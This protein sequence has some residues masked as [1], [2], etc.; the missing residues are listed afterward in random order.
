MTC[1]PARLE[2]IASIRSDKVA[3]LISLPILLCC[4]VFLL[5][6]V[7]L[8]CFTVGAGVVGWRG[9]LGVL[10][11]WQ[12]SSVAIGTGQR[13]ATVSISRCAPSGQ[14]LRSHVAICHHSNCLGIVNYTHS[15]GGQV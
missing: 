1:Q 3:A 14:R 7:N 5:A 12:G 8:R 13:C 10:A 4:M 11:G 6:V 15:L 2:V 9:K